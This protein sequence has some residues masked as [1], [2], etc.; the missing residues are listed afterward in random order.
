MSKQGAADL[1]G[2]VMASRAQKAMA[3][4]AN[5]AAAEKKERE[6]NLLVPV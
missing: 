3:S 5:V 4:K 2:R 6:K 1:I